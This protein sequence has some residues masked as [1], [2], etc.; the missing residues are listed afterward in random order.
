MNNAPDASPVDMRA[1]DAGDGAQ[2]G[3]QSG[4]QNDARA[5]DAERTE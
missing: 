4:A 5:E 2:S 1:A 3:A